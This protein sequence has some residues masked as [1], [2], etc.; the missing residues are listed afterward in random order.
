MTHTTRNLLL[1]A[2]LLVLTQWIVVPVIRWQAQVVDTV[3]QDLSKIGARESLIDT[4]PEMQREQA[5]RTQQI[6]S[7]SSLSFPQGPSAILELQRWVTASLEGTSLII[8]KFEW[9]PQ[10]QGTISMVTATIFV[11]GGEQ[12]FFE[13]LSQL[14][15]GEVW[16]GIESFQV[17]KS[18]RQM[19]DGVISGRVSIKFIL[20]DRV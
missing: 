14:Q 7:L 2:V 13:W 9:S 12:Q 11:K 20:E 6:I 5:E 1:I 8:D 19:Y 16:V 15:T 4:L 10:S 17:R 3:E 18:D